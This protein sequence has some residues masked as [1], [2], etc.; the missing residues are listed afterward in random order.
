[1]RKTIL[2][3]L[4]LFSLNVWSQHL[5]M[6]GIPLDGSIENFTSK[7]SSKGI[8]IDKELNKLFP[9]GTRAFKG[10]FSGYYASQ[11]LFFYDPRTRTVFKGV[12][13]FTDLPN[14]TLQNMYDDIRAK[15]LAKY[16]NPLLFDD[17][18]DDG[19]PL[20][21]IY[22]YNQKTD[23]YYGLIQLGI[24]VMKVYPYSTVFYV[25]YED[26]INKYKFDKHSSDDL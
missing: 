24:A 1:M 7:L 17:K 18:N 9:N 3:L 25:S 14:Q 11:I 6:F 5:S 26:T 20:C 4:T 2:I 22:V 8:T 16:E 23:T 21:K 10:S 12:A 13:S 19:L 15:I